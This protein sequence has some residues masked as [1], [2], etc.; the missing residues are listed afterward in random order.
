M[1]YFVG[2][3]SGDPDLITLKGYK[4]LQQADVVV[5]AGSL[6]NPEVLSHA[7]EGAKIVNSAHLALEE[8][9]REMVEGY[10]VGKLVVRLHTGD[11]S[12]YGAIGEQIDMLNE[13]N[14]PYKV[15]PG[16]SSFLAAAASLGR[17]YTIPDGTQTMIVTRLEGRTPVPASESLK[18]LASHKSSMAIF[19]SVG[20]I[21][22]V[23]EELSQVHPLDMPIAV[24]EKASWPEERIVKG[25]LETIGELTREA[26]IT[27]TALI[28]VGEF[29]NHT[30]KSKLYD[31]D[32]AHEYRQ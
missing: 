13:F 8:I 11:P 15:V 21:D 22:R 27:K 16:V 18:S 26:G 9:V 30:G 31:K 23:V 17:E 25:T 24:V 14:I 3:G 10:Q 1:I 7:K 5:Y 28:L 32:F 29:L 4:L 2:A 12:L 20:M 6:V 19:L